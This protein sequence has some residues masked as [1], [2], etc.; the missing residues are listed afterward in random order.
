MGQWDPWGGRGEGSYGSHPPT[1]KKKKPNTISS[2]GP[3]NILFKGVSPFH[4][5][6]SHYIWEGR[7][8]ISIA[9]NVF[10]F[11]GG[12]S[13]RSH[14][15]WG[16]GGSSASSSLLTYFILVGGAVTPLPITFYFGVGVSIPL[17]WG[18]GGVFRPPPQLLSVPFG[19]VAVHVEVAGDGRE[20]EDSALQRR[21]E[22]Q[23][24][25]QPRL[26]AQLRGCIQEVLLPKVGGG[27]EIN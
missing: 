6:V 1:S 10:Y 27:K 7:V 11:L 22:R 26:H 12:V 8:L 13:I 25:A 15:I 20:S 18:R 4:P 19:D 24:A 21:E 2:G 23:L 3:H 9:V 17:Y 16:E 14:Y 5:I